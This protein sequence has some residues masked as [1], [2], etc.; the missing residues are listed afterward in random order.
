MKQT[1]IL[2]GQLNCSV[3]L[4]DVSTRC[5]F[6]L[7]MTRASSRNI[8]KFYRTVKL[9]AKNLHLFHNFILMIVCFTAVCRP[10]LHE[11]RECQRKVKELERDLKQTRLAEHYI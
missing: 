6:A 5:S 3:K 4:A 7:R 8:G 1:K 2:C 11:L 9:S 10:E